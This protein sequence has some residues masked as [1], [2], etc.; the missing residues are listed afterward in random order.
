MRIH[1]FDAAL[2]YAT[3]HH[4]DW[5]LRIAAALARRGH[6]VAVWGAVGLDPALAQAIS[7]PGVRCEGLFSHFAPD[8]V[9]QVSVPDGLLALAAT[10]G[11][12]IE[13][14]GPADLRLFPSLSA[15]HLAALATVERQSPVSGMVHLNLAQEHAGATALWEWALPKL[16]ERHAALKLGAIDPAIGEPFRTLPLAWPVEDWPQPIDGVVL[17]AS[18][19][20]RTIGFFGHQ[21][22][23]RGVTLI[24]ALTDRLLR[25]GYRVIVHDSRGAIRSGSS[26]PGL[27]LIRG[28]VRDLAPVLGECD[29][30]VCPMDVEPYRLRTS[31]IASLAT[32]CGRPLVLP[33]GTLSARRFLPAGAVGCYAEPSVEALMATI[34]DMAAH[35]AQRSAAALRAAAD[36]AQTQGVERFVDAVLLP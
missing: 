29:L 28:F 14:A 13:T 25:A 26:I 7:G 27:K 5:A 8:G 24:P 18:D 6:E 23:E 31:G 20:L 34:E 22:P 10:A 1:L 32:A 17:P 4:A 33:E 16:R 35:H 19:R 15:L 36:W 30:V 3:G 21:R 11:R 9:E 12:E 2:R